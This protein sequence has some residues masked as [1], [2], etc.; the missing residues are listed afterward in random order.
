MVFVSKRWRKHVFDDEGNINRQ[1]YE[2]AAL[3]ELK[4]YIRSGDVWVEGSRLHKDFEEYLVSKDNW[5]KTKDKG[6]NIA[7]NVSFD[8]YIQDRI[9]T[10]NTKLQWISLTSCTLKYNTL[11]ALFIIKG[12]L[13]IKELHEEVVNKYP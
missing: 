9:E 13:K 10:L 7:V 4:N 1:Y 8:R 3:T 2:M 5:A 6:T 11:N 12:L